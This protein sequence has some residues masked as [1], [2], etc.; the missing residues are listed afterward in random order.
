MTADAR[1]FLSRAAGTGP[2]RTPTSAVLPFPS[3]EVD[4]YRGLTPHLE[5][6][7]ARARALHGLATG[8]ARLVV[9]SARALLPRLID[10]VAARRGG[11]D[12][13]ARAARSSPQD[14]GERLA[15]A[16]FIAGGSRSTS[17]ASS[18]CA[19]ASSTSI[20]RREAQP[21]RLEFIGDIVE[22]IRRYDAAT[23]RSLDRARSD[24]R[25]RRSASCCRSGRAGRSRPRSI[26]SATIVDYARRAGALGRRRSR[27][28]TS[29]SAAEA[30][31]EQWRAAAADMTARGRTVPPYEAIARAVAT[32]S[33]AGCDPAHRISA[34]GVDRRRRIGAS[35]HRVRAGARQYHGR[36][37][38]WADEIRDARERG[39][40]RSCSS[41]PRP[42]APSARSSCSPTTTSARAIGRRCRRPRERRRARHDRPAVAR[43]PP[44]GGAACCS[45]PR[46]I[47]SRRNAACTSA[48]VR[49]ART[50]IS[51]FRDLKIGDLVVHVDNGIGR[52]VGLK[53]LGVARRAATRRSSWSSAT[54]A[55]TSCSS[56][57]SGSISSRNTRAAPTPALDK[58]GGT[59]WE[60]AKTRVKK[61]MRDMAEE[62][63]KL[64][65]ARKAVVGHAFSP[66][67][68]WQQEFGD[69]FEYDLT[70][71]SADRDR[72]HH[73]R[74]GVADA[75]GSPALRRR[76]LRQDR[77]RDARGVQGRDGRQA[78]RVP[79]ADDGPRVSAPADAE[80]A[81][82]RLPGARST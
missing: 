25:S 44:A 79:G 57:S 34:A 72:R 22:S 20:R 75:D 40:A 30:L 10:P 29:T 67:S 66:D 3:Q 17:T 62:L 13:R 54:P 74:H 26:G 46:P 81:V 23:Q 15:L 27:S 56:R 47:S 73:A 7:S 37:G 68:H 31:E 63:L 45:S 21:V 78:G 82:R 65:A 19:A 69:A 50:F 61:A 16:G 12:D 76:R 49:R 2:T 48:A 71:G 39:D 36:I 4:P 35:T 33:A 52:F 24:H 8:T 11:P 1:L 43:V 58:L 60:K 6:A 42:A 5:V 28:T 53:K 77:S 64:Y 59:T 32:V 70:T 14:L 18:A 38:D 55:R 51:D 80:G 9:A 41:P